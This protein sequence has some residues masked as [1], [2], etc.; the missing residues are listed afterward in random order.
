MILRN[1]ETSEQ[2]AKPDEIEPFSIYI[3]TSTFLN[4]LTKG[5]PRY[6][7]VVA[8]TTSI[9]GG[10]KVAQRRINPQRSQRHRTLG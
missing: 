6:G 8:N 3:C 7:S 1:N 10:A 5:G 9:S 2:W 4:L